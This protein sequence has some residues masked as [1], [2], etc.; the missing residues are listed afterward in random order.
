MKYA[1]AIPLD[2]TARLHGVDHFLIQ[3]L[4]RILEEAVQQAIRER[5]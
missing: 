5:G 4:L 2:S 3:G 1:F